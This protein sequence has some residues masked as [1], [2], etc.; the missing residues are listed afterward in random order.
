[1]PRQKQIQQLVDHLLEQSAVTQPPVPIRRIAKSHGLDIRKESI[2]DSNISGFLLRRGRDCI[3]GVNADD[4][5]ARQRFTIAHE[6]GH[7]LLNPS[8]P[9]GFHVD[10]VFEVKFRDTK[11][12]KGTD[13]DERD[14][15]AFAAEILMPRHFL[16]QDIEAAGEVDWV[17]DEF[18]S[19]LA[20]KYRVSNQ[21]LLIRLAHLGYVR[22]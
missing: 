10:R 15:N 13:P 7:F 6:L 14:A 11:S 16:A 5:P 20:R 9:D 22:V 3:V 17:E 12:A 21:A 1:M 18:L 2:P 4:S 19:R 8:R